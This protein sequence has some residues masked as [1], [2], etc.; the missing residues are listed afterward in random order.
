MSLLHVYVSR[1]HSSRS[2][3]LLEFLNINLSDIVKIVETAGR[4]ILSPAFE[5]QSKQQQSI[6]IKDDGSIVTK[7]DL[8]CQI[9]LQQQL[10]QLAPNIDFLGEEMSPAAQLTALESEKSFWCVDPLDGTSNFACPMP[11]FA[12]S[13]ALIEHGQPTLACIHDP[14]RQ[15]TFTAI[16]GQGCKLNHTCIS[17]PPARELKAASGFIDFKRLESKVAI[18]LATKKVYYSQRNIG[19]CAL[20]WAWLATAR[21]QFII[22]GGEKIW[23]YAAGILLAEEAGCTVTNFLGEKPFSKVQLSSSIIASIPHIHPAILQT[24]DSSKT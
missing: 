9:F 14:I 12:I 5:Q 24:I 17:P 18:H 16:K 13:I 19:S 7:T 4:D 22:H 3:I 8:A 20:E 21:G 23:D 10:Q 15:E 6:S 2:F 1:H 11:L